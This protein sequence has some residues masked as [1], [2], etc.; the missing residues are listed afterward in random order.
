VEPRAAGSTC[1]QQQCG[2]R[3][4]Q[5]GEQIPGTAG[6]SGCHVCGDMG[7]RAADCAVA[8]ENWIV[9]QMV[10]HGVDWTKVHVIKMMAK[11]EGRAEQQRREQESWSHVV[12]RG[13]DKGA[14]RRPSAAAQDKYAEKRKVRQAQQAA[15]A[16]KQRASAAE[17]A[18]RRGEYP[19][20]WATVAEAKAKRK[21]AEAQRR[22]A[23]Y[24]QQVAKQVQRTYRQQDELWQAGQGRHA[25]QE[26][27]Y[28]PQDRDSLDRAMGSLGN[29][30]EAEVAERT[31]K[32]E[33]Q[34]AQEQENEAKQELAKHRRVERS[35]A[36]KVQEQQ[37]VA[38]QLQCEQQQQLWLQQQLQQQAQQS[39]DDFIRDILGELDMEM[40]SNDGDT[41]TKTQKKNAKKRAKHSG[42]VP[43]QHDVNMTDVSLN[44]PCLLIPC[45][46]N[47]CLAD[48]A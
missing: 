40:E 24:R 43:L 36:Q 11:A 41:K 27:R 31:A 2:G 30:I 12:Q 16:A 44:S 47:S 35:Q 10:Q 39:E 3:R 29:Q 38:Q 1:E 15:R 32:A 37:A 45:L 18:V 46:A 34:R 28:R 7:H 25:Q 5:G 48:Q 42:L 26:N 17:D 14:R 20:P 8:V 23:V 9:Q 33:L 13:E 19:A 21:E 4:Q 22:A 6:Y